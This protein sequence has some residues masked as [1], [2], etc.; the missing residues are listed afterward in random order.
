MEGKVNYTVVGI[1]VLL[2]GAMLFSAIIWL[3]SADHGKLYSTYVVYVHED[4]TGLSLESPVRFNGVKIGYVESMRLDRANSKLVRLMLKIEPDVPITTTT[5]AILNAQGVTGVV[6]VNLKATTETAPPLIALPGQPYPVIPAHPSF[7]TQLNE[8]LPEVAADIRK[9]S[10][11]VSDLM[12]QQNRES[13]RTSLK[14]IASITETLKDNSTEFTDTM[15]HMNHAL[16]NISVASN[17]FPETVTKMNDTLTSVNTLSKQ[18]NKT[19]VTIDDTMKS[20][21]Q[22]IR[23]FSNQVM[24]SAQQALSNLASTTQSANILMQ[25]LQKDPSMLVRGKQPA[26]L[27]PGE[28]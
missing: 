19:A 11:S 8:A 12:D 14:N 5:Y 28:K 2:L 21:Q 23:N 1:F 6:Y 15:Q 16:A 18:L 9:L 26:P 3:T 17:H 7:L 20:G 24:P 13:L 10:A 22:T 25:E 27:G 4:V